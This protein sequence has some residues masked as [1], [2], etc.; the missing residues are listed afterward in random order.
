[1]YTQMRENLNASIRQ[2]ENPAPPENQPTPQ[3]FLEM[4][5]TE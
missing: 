2:G 4:G 3:N 5:G 1:M